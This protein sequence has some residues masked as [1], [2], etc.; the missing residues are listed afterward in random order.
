MEC[1]EALEACNHDV[2]QALAWLIK[3]GQSI[4]AK[5]NRITAEGA[6]YSYSSGKKGGI[7]E[8]IRHNL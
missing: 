3:R 7:V 4:K 6:V 5:E 1:K 2:D 8:V